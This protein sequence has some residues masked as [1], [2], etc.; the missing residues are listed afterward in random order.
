MNTF[1]GCFF[2]GIIIYSLIVLILGIIKRVK[3]KKRVKKEN[4]ERKK[5]EDEQNQSTKD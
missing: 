1:I 4:E 5:Q 2:I 3:N